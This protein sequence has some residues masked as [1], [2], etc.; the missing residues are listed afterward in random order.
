MRPHLT[1][2][3]HNGRAGNYSLML[4][5]AVIA[6]LGFGALSIDTAYMRLSQAQAQDVADAASQ[7]A[8][9]VLR[10]TGDQARATDAA[11]QIIGQN[12]VAGEAPE[13]LDITYGNWDDTIADPVF[14]ID[15]VVPNAV[16]VTV[17]RVDDHAIPVLLARIWHVD[18][19]G[20]RANAISATRSFQI[21]FVMDI[22][23]SWGESKY[24]DAREAVLTALDMVSSSASGVDEVGMTIFTNRYAWE[25]TPFTQ[26]AVP[27]NAAAVEADWAKL[28]IASKGGTDNDHDDGRP[29]H[30][31]SLAKRNIFTDPDGGCY[32][33]MPREYT[34]EPGT[35]H[36]TGIGLA[37][38]MFEDSSTGA[39]YRAMIVVTDG[40]PNGLGASSGTIRADQGYVEDRWTEY[41]GPVPRTGGEIRTETIAATQA[42]WDDLRVH[43]WAV[44]LV[45]D[46]WMLDA[47]VHGD[48]Y[49]VV[50]SDSS[51]L[52]AVVSEIISEMPLAIVQ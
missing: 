5:T 24:L 51:Q 46:D 41:V 17:G 47:M 9:I 43:T 45:V 29:C 39:V 20:V 26:I 13:L 2:R 44:T 6:L 14:T 49:K 31:K 12:R 40:R 35:D 38:Q 48:G 11:E 3:L 7:A 4:A 1:K 8:L 15:P 10:Q 22:T 30:L 36:S 32:P 37:R 50:V 19:F 23:G 21:V 16:S 27:A 18:D 33:D 28:N 42:M 34:D 52:A 25:Y